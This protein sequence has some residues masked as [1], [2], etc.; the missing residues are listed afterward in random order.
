MSIEILPTQQTPKIRHFS[1]ISFS[2][3]H[4]LKIR[5]WA[6]EQTIYLMHQQPMMH[7]YA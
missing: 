6:G 7:A 4:L 1:R 3:R 2:S 5:K